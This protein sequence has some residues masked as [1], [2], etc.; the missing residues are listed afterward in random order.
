MSILERINLGRLY[1]G[2]NYCAILTAGG[3]NMNKWLIL[4]NLT[5]TV[6]FVASLITGCIPADS[7]KVEQNRALID[8][9]RTY[10]RE[11]TIGLSESINSVIGAVDSNKQSIQAIGEYLEEDLNEYIEARID[12]Y[13]EQEVKEL[14][15][16]LVLD[17]LP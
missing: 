2:P 5:L 13:V 9:N 1:L 11:T 10:I 14:V 3:E 8:E 7:A 16:E 12:A 4:W 17:L 15:T 6:L